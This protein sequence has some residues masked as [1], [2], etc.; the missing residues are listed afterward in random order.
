[1]HLTEALEDAKAKNGTL[2][3]IDDGYNGFELYILVIEGKAPRHLYCCPECDYINE[4][5]DICEHC[6]YGEGFPIH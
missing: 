1:M 2:S 4:A 5:Y 3:R 6:C